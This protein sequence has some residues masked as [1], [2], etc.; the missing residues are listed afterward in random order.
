MESSLNQCLANTHLYT[1][2]QPAE[3]AER[4]GRTSIETIIKSLKA[5]LQIVE[6]LRAEQKNIDHIKLNAQIAQEKLEQHEEIVKNYER[7]FSERTK[8]LVEENR[9]LK[10][11]NDKM[12]KAFNESEDNYKAASEEMK[13]QCEHLRLRQAE[14]ECENKKLLMA[15]S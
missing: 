15:I 12:K 11:A 9:M 6:N 5:V 14:L 8:T 10:E 3:D 4:L 1:N 13:E 2:L 7:K